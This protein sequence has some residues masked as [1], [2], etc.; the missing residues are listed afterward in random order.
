MALT[1]NTIYL[2]IADVRVGKRGDTDKLCRRE[3]SSLGVTFYGELYEREDDPIDVT[4][5]GELCEGEDDPIYVFFHGG[6]RE[7]QVWKVLRRAK[8]DGLGLD[9]GSPDCAF[10]VILRHLW[11]HR[12]KRHKKEAALGPNKGP[13]TLLHTIPMVDVLCNYQCLY[14]TNKRQPF[15]HG[16]P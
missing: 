1:N 2:W 6:F 4:F 7:K 12:T 14:S 5:D 10:R 15:A 13:V 16:F 11:R 9:D 3:W 8:K